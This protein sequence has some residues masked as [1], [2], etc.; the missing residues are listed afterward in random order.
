LILP[1]AM[2]VEKNGV[3]GNSERRT[4]QWFKMVQ[5]PGEARDDCWQTLAVAHQL[6]LDGFAGMKKKDGSFLFHFED[7]NGKTVPVWDWEKYYDHNVDEFLF[8]EYRQFTTIKH[9]NVAPY[10]ELVKAR[11]MRWPVVQDKNGVWKD[12][13]YRFV[14]GSDPFVE[15][16]KKF[17]FYHS[18]TGDDRAM[19]FFRPYVPPPEMP[20]N[21]Y[22]FWLDTGRVLEHWHSG[23][24]TMRV[25][26][27][28]K[29]MPS[30]YVEVNKEDA[31]KLGIRTGDK[32]KLETRRGEIQLNA[33]IDGRASCPPG[34][35][36]VPFFDENLLINELTLEAHCPIS[37]QP[38]YKKCA[39]RI[40]KVG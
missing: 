21:E 31:R 38:D 13:A 23:T 34:H 22:P 27:L 30:A 4:Q 2:W 7:K 25:P 8:E 3:F 28:R 1:S 35:L 5:P 12:T 39:V 9:K 15:K 37:K 24:M 19:I 20:D 36:F 17:Q 40:S 6:F 11:G 16:G 26:P 33:W 10:Q 18:T 14:E 32:V 29:S